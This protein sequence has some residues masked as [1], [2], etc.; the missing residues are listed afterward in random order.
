MLSASKINYISTNTNAIL[1]FGYEKFEFGV[2]S[3]NLIS[4]K[5]GVFTEKDEEEKSPH[6]I[7]SYLLK[8]KNKNELI[9]STYFR[10]S[11]GDTRLTV[12]E[13]GHKFNHQ[14][15]VGITKDY[16]YR[17]NKKISVGL[18]YNLISLIGKIISI[19]DH[20]SSSESLTSTDYSI[21]F[22]SFDNINLNIRFYLSD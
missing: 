9:N 4:Q 3:V 19:N 2:N 8:E 15:Q 20:I 5:T 22:I 14:F 17:I 11:V 7:I 12:K 1:F 10:Y 18:R 16:S 6:I 13:W 21:Q